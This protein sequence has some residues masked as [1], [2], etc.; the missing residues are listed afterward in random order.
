[1]LRTCVSRP[2]KSPTPAPPAAPA[3]RHQ[4]GLRG[5][6]C[7]VVH[8]RVRDVEAEQERAE[9]L[10]LEHGLQRPLAHLWLVGRVG[11]RELRT[12][13]YLVDDRWDPMGIGTRAE[14]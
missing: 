11:G 8:A 12:E 1:M 9:G 2:A 10:K 4:H 5:R 6:R 3:P 7:A 14:E 13:Q